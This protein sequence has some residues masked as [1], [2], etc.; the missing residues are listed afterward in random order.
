[1]EGTKHM[2][3]AVP[4]VALYL[5]N[6]EDTHTVVRFYDTVILIDGKKCYTLSKH[7]YKMEDPNGH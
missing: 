2:K 5:E 1:M 6:L 7:I 4:R 3:I